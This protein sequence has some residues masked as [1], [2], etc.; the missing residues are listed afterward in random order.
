L[1]LLFEPF[2]AFVDVLLN[3]F[4]NRLRRAARGEQRRG[5]E[6]QQHQRP[7]F[8]DFHGNS[9]KVGEV[10]KATRILA[11]NSTKQIA[12]SHPNFIESA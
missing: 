10:G 6:A 3:F 8:H 5:P 12:I 7:R 1:L 2:E 9:S 11:I 4:R